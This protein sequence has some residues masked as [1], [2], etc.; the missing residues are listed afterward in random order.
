MSA[1]LPLTDGLIQ[2]SPFD[3]DCALLADRH[4]SRQTPGS[5]QFAGNGKKCVLRDAAG[6]VLFVWLWS[7]FRMDGQRGYN[8][9]IFRNESRRL[10]SDVILEAEGH[11]IAKWGAGRAFTYVDPSKVQ[12]RNPG[13]CFRRAGW[14]HVA[15]KKD[16]KF[17]FEKELT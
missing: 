7:E 11:A 12:S 6:E 5:P 3:R 2:T 15:T 17:L 13:Y 14:L 4:Y 16:G 8:C 9:A 1:L 10:S